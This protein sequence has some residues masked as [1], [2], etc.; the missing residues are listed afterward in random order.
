MSVYLLIGRFPFNQ[1]VGFESSTTSSSEWNSIFLKF[2][3]TFS[4]AVFFP[5]HFAPGIPRFFGWMVR[6]SEIQ[7]FSEFLES[8]AGHFCTICRCFQFFESFG[9]KET[10]LVSW[11][12]PYSC[13]LLSPGLYRRFR[14]TVLAPVADQP[15][16]L[17][18]TAPFRNLITDIH[19]VHLVSSQLQG[20][21]STGHLVRF[22]CKAWF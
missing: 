2:P 6:I 18:S 7:Q 10:T 3:K 4:L 19:S 22:V 17:S 20:P 13:L 11:R 9:G 16:P 15:F 21:C 12:T 1:N 5:F 14:R 8:F